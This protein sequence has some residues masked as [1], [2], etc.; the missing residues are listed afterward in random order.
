MGHNQIERLTISHRVYNGKQRCAL[1]MHARHSPRRLLRSQ[2]QTLQQ[3]ATATWQAFV[4]L[5]Y[6]S[7]LPADSINAAGERANYTSPTN[8]GAY[9]WSTLVARDLHLITSAE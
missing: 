1:S 4:V 5:T 9:L 7:G 3:Y 2:H 8:I 6:P